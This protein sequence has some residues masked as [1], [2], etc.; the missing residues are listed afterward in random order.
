MLVQSAEKLILNNLELIEKGERACFVTIGYFTLEQFNAINKFRESENLPLLLSNEII[1]L[2]RHHYES[3][4]IKD[5]YNVLDLVKQIKSALTDQSVISINRGRTG[6]KSIVA[7][8]D[9]YGNQVIDVAAFELMA[10]KPRAELYSVIP[11]GDKIKP[12]K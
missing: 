11:T 5:G 6:L 8:D 3:R 7:R 12:K 10:R 2:G 4:V 9:G 1:Y